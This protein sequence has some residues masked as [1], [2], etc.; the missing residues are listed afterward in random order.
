M[1]DIVGHW[2]PPGSTSAV[3][4][5]IVGLAWLHGFLRGCGTRES[6]SGR[7]VLAVA[8]ETRLPVWVQ[9]SIWSGRRQLCDNG[10]VATGGQPDEG[11]GYGRAWG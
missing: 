10:G 3:D 4:R 5:K 8:V 6:I 11:Q 9:K 7:V 2:L 1:L